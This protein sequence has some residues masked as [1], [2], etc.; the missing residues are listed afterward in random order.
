M[1]LERND[2]LVTQKPR[3]RVCLVFRRIL[4][5]D[6]EL[7]VCARSALMAMLAT[8]VMLALVAL[9]PLAAAHSSLI[10]PKPRNAIDSELPAWKDG[11]SPYYWVKGIGK[12]GAPCACRNG[13]ESCASAQT[14]LWYV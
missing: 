6:Q 14:C 1:P 5:K 9:L 8:R 3:P 13:T 7:G 4:L 10:T 12:A 2:F 11:L